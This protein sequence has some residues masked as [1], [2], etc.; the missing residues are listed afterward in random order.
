MRP[1]T[2]I[3][4]AP[5]SLI[6]NWSG[7]LID[8]VIRK[9]F[10]TDNILRIGGDVYVRVISVCKKN[11]N[12]FVGIVEDP[13]IDN[14]SWHRNGEKIT[15]HRRQV[16]EVPLDWS[17]NKNLEKHARLRNKARSFTGAI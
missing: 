14:F 3:S 15:F 9:Y 11:S 1:K 13:Y 5:N 6:T 10:Q 4:R 16:T 12:C 8:P 2:T 17:G 7:R